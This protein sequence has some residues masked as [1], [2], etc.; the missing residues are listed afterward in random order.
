MQATGYTASFSSLAGRN[1]TFLLALILMVSPVAGF[2]HPGRPLPQLE[3]AETGQADFVT[4]LQMA[5]GQRHQIAEHGL[6]LL[7][8]DLMAVGQR[9]AEVLERNGR[10]RRS[11]RWGGFL[12]RL[13]DLPGKVYRPAKRPIFRHDYRNLLP[14]AGDF[15]MDAIAD[16]PSGK[17]HR[18]PMWRRPIRI[19]R[20]RKAF[21][22]AG[23]AG[24]LAGFPAGFDPGG[25][26][27]SK[28]LR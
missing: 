6:S 12:R 23:S 8:C 10:L 11:L 1:A 14:Q 2:P 13:A 26:M 24:L 20:C 21:L 3:D 17:D 5:G 7:L 27:P 16:V 25:H 4:P 19:S 22:N 28:L 15:E 18:S 9:G